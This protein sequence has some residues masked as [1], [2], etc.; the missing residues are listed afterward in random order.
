MTVTPIMP[1]RLSVVQA[2][3]DEFCHDGDAEWIIRLAPPTWQNSF[4]DPGASR[5]VRP[6]FDRHVDNPLR[7]RQMAEFRQRPRQLRF[8]SPMNSA[9]ITKTATTAMK[10][11]PAAEP[12]R[13]PAA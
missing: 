5:R 12:E 11:S 9:I 3:A 2:G 6:Y 8:L 1:G 10:A 7:G 4:P 13:V